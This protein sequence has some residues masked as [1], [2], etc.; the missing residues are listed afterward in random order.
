MAIATLTFDLSNQDDRIEHLRCI[1]SL[2]MANA[3]FE[4]THNL[5]KKCEHICG[6]M[7]A[8]SD[9]HDGVYLVF[10]KINSILEDNEI[11]ID[12]LIR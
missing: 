5:K 11:N 9:Q 3:L 8:D 1:K 7:E 12:E 10:Q 4:I 2:E 6:S